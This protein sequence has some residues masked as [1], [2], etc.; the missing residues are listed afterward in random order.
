MPESKMI[1]EAL[2]SRT[3]KAK[4]RVYF[5]DVKKA[6]T[7]IKYLT[8]VDSWIK[9]G[10]KNRNTL[11]IFADQAENFTQAFEEAKLMLR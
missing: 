7:G 1:P 4:G 11:T 5:F 9:E 10:Q 6:K 8:I 3:L 2:F